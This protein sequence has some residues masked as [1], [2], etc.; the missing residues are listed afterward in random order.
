MEYD[1]KQNVRIVIWY[2]FGWLR[3]NGKLKHN[4]KYEYIRYC[5]AKKIYLQAHLSVQSWIFK[6]CRPYTATC[7]A[8][9]TATYLFKRHTSRDKF[10]H[11]MF[12]SLKI[13][14]LDYFL[15]Y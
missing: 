7:T 8:G 12:K 3:K 13:T 2:K 5:E 4:W 14:L 10:Y 6:L 15:F 11:L 1:L 9:V